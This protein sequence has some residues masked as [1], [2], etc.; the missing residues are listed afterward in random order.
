MR[1]MYTSIIKYI[2]DV[3][4]T[5]NILITLIQ[6]NHYVYMVTELSHM[7]NLCIW[8]IASGLQINVIMLDKW[9]F[10]GKLD[11]NVEMVCRS[12]IWHPFTMTEP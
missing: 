4:N 2:V 9:L 11:W 3:V 7:L 6:C 10:P 1:M 5:Y 12:T 8:Y